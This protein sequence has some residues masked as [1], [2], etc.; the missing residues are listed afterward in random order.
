MSDETI[1]RTATTAAAG[2][3]L[4]FLGRHTDLSEIAD[5]FA[6]FKL[7]QRVGAPSKWK[8]LSER[9]REAILGR[10]LT[11]ERQRHTAN[12]RLDKRRSA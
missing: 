11:E 4:T 3:R 7:A 8:G 1:A 6:S 9:L 12:G 2:R 10:P 5:R